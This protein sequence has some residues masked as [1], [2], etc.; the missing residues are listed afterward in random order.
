MA[1]EWECNTILA[2]DVSISLTFH[3]HFQRHFFF[4]ELHDSSNGP[5]D[6]LY[7]RRRRMS[8]AV[9][10]S[11]AGCGQLWQSRRLHISTTITPA[12]HQGQDLLGC[13]RGRANSHHGLRGAQLLGTSRLSK[14]PSKLHLSEHFRKIPWKTRRS[15]QVRDHRDVPLVVLQ[16]PNL[17]QISPTSCWHYPLHH[18]TLYKQARSPPL[19]L[20]VLSDIL[21]VGGNLSCLYNKATAQ[22]LWHHIHGNPNIACTGKEDFIRWLGGGS[23]WGGAVGEGC[24]WDAG[25]CWE[26]PGCPPG[27][28]HPLRQCLPEPMMLTFG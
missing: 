6:S 25:L 22:C 2:T 28:G 21:G 3:L 11:W 4:L 13:A 10:L 16:L 8:W 27:L 12:P 26:G 7:L 20:P 23:F 9:L 1:G 24:F 15:C 17:A 19:S 14:Q 5:R 18:A